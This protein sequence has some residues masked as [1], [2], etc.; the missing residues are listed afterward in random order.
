LCGVQEE[1]QE[2]LLQQVHSAAT[3]S[4]HVV[5]GDSSLAQVTWAVGLPAG[6]PNRK[7]TLVIDKHMLT[8]NKISDSIEYEVVDSVAHNDQL[9]ALTSSKVAGLQSMLAPSECGLTERSLGR[10][11]CDQQAAALTHLQ[12]ELEDCV[13]RADEMADVR[14]LQSKRYGGITEEIHELT[15]ANMKAIDEVVAILKAEA[16]LESRDAGGLHFDPVSLRLRDPN[17]ML[18]QSLA[19]VQEVKGGVLLKEAS[20]TRLL[21][22]IKTAFDCKEC[23]ASAT[24]LRALKTQTHADHTK[25]TNACISMAEI[26]RPSD[27]VD[28]EKAI[29]LRRDLDDMESARKLREKTNLQLNSLR[30]TTIHTTSKLKG[31]LDFLRLGEPFPQ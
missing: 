26:H 15:T 2:I 6:E 16:L 27:E 12:T 24:Q 10:R 3:A 8:L 31:F 4:E 25:A 21:A 14:A 20:Q 17:E 18:D 19:I 13:E 1:D 11:I 30:K 29:T 28:R 9:N 7:T 23:D 22:E 5:P